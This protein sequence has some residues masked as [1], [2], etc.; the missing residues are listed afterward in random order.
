MASMRFWFLTKDT[1]P[2]ENFGVS[3]PCGTSLTIPG[4]GSDLALIIQSIVKLPP[5]DERTFDVS[6]GEEVDLNKVSFQAELDSMYKPEAVHEAK[7]AKE[8]QENRQRTKLFNDDDDK[9]KPVEDAEKK[10]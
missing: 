4:Q 5:L 9:D 8:R 2:A 7:L 3:V 1:E 10:E 6:S